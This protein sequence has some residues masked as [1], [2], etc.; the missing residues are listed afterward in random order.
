MNLPTS[1]A[2]PFHTL[3][4]D[5]LQMIRGALTLSITDRRG[6][7]ISSVTIG[8][9][10]GAP[11]QEALSL[12]HVYGQLAYQRAPSELNEISVSR[13]TWCWNSRELRVDDETYYL[14]LVCSSDPL[15]SATSPEIERRLNELESK[16]QS[17][18]SGQR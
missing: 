12:I 6:D 10:A 5:H 17:L 14:W 7:Q 16:L 2:N 3:L 1:S 18:L 8:E 4:S 15:S 13:G 9:N 11:S